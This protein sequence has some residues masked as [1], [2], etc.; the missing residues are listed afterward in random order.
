MEGSDGAGD[1]R[2]LRGML[3]AAV[4]DGSAGEMPSV[5]SLIARCEAAGVDREGAKR[6]VAELIARDEVCE[7]WSDWT[8]VNDRDEIRLRLEVIARSDSWSER[9]APFVIFFFRASVADLYQPAAVALG[10]HLHRSERLRSYI[11]GYSK[12]RGVA[13]DKPV[14]LGGGR[15][16]RRVLIMLCAARGMPD[17]GLGLPSMPL[18]TEGD[19]RRAELPESAADLAVTLQAIGVLVDGSPGDDVVRAIAED[20][21]DRTP[22]VSPGQAGRTVLQRYGGLLARLPGEATVGRWRRMFLA[23]LEHLR[24]CQVDAYA[25]RVAGLIRVDEMLRTAALLEDGRGRETLGVV[26]AQ[27]SELESALFAARM[28]V[29]WSRERRGDASWRDEAVREVERAEGDA[30]ERVTTAAV[31]GWVCRRAGGRDGRGALFAGA[32]AAPAEFVLLDRLLGCIGSR[33]RWESIDDPTRALLTAML[34]D[35]ARHVGGGSGVSVVLRRHGMAAAEGESETAGDVLLSRVLLR[36]LSWGGAGASSFVDVR[37]IHRI[38][39]PRVLLALLPPGER[40]PVLS[41]IADAFEHQIRWRLRRDA[42]FSPDALLRMALV[43]RPHASFFESLWAVCTGRT[44]RDSSGAEVD[45]PRLAAAAAADARWRAGEPLPPPVFGDEGAKHDETGVREGLAALAAD[46][47]DLRERVL[48]LAN[49]IGD[50]SG[51]RAA[52][53]GTLIALLEQT[54]AQHEPF[55]VHGYPAWSA[56]TLA[57]FEVELAKD[58]ARARVLVSRALPQRWAE[59]DA[60]REALLSLRALLDRVAEELAAALPRVEAEMLAGAVGSMHRDLSRWAELLGEIAEA[61]PETSARR[62]DAGE[63]AAAMARV[64]SIDSAV[65]RSHLLGVLWRSSQE[66]ASEGESA[67]EAFGY[68]RALLDGLLQ[69]AVYKDGDRDRALLVELG[70]ETWAQLVADASLR[71]EESRVVALIEDPLYAE[72]RRVPAAGDALRDASRWCLDRYLIGPAGSVAR[73]LDGG[74]GRW[75]AFGRLI[76]HYSTVWVSLLIG[77]IFML[78]FGDAW[79]EMAE[80]RDALGIAIT[81]LL[82]IAGAFGYIY[83]NLRRKS[84]LSPGQSVRELRASHRRRAAAFAGV[85]L[86]Y[87]LAATGGLWLLLSGT[88]AVVK[89]AGAVGHIVVWSGFAMF[90]GVFFGLIAGDT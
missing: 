79:T 12:D 28:L 49:L 89:G 15:T 90:V 71:N 4:S 13:I 81:F 10:R 42:S 54:G 21:L 2:S 19:G 1:R 58:L 32:E 55:V 76:V 84:L 20:A 53:R 83:W 36:V 78:D 48:R 24:A 45:V 51:E 72:L 50:P 80:N 60:S 70:A 11:A 56:G 17:A 67:S 82:G 22:A 41:V 18:R 74:A 25:D 73:D 33:E 9:L 68:R 61:W 63:L 86:L 52:P 46:S 77:A 6:A 5:R 40:S 26:R 43:R 30:E 3:E 59:L 14:K 64:A 85:C 7:A 44:Y 23:Q 16:Q 75:S 29:W 37:T 66:R 69:S 65:V 87:S 57:E 8:A 38:D 62:A 31:V 39:D 88:D 27:C 35:A 47:P 34:L